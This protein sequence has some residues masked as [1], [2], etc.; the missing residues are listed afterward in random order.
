MF[1]V[2]TLYIQQCTDMYVYYELKASPPSFDIAQKFLLIVLHSFPS[3]VYWYRDFFQ[4]CFDTYYHT[5]FIIINFNT[6]AA[7][8]NQQFK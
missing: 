7:S 8:M 4:L 5:I 2:H 3:L 6:H 1:N